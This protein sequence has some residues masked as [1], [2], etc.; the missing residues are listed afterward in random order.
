MSQLVDRV[1]IKAVQAKQADRECIKQRVT[2]I[3]V[4]IESVEWCRDLLNKIQVGHQKDF[5]AVEMHMDL[6]MIIFD[7]RGLHELK[8]DVVFYHAAY[9]DGLIALTVTNA[10]TKQMEKVW[11][12]GRQSLSSDEG[13]SDEGPL[14]D[15]ES[16]INEEPPEEPFTR[17]LSSNKDNY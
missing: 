9:V 17:L 5:A 16:H 1:I 10:Q 11:D 12:V 7:D 2:Q 8:D 13:H 4:E 15:E 14:A 6:S 3:K